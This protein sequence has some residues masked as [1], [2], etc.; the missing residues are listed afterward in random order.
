MLASE[1]VTNSVRHGDGLEVLLRWVVD[2]ASVVVEVC[3]GGSGFSAW[4][5]R[6]LPERDQTGGRGLFLVDRLATRWGTYRAG[7]DVCV[8]FEIER[9]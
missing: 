7:A 9:A 2:D 8:W 4:P 6:P 3:D 1:L 5:P